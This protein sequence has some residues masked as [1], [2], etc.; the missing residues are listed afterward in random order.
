MAPGHDSRLCGVSL[1]D[2][3]HKAVKVKPRAA[4]AARGSL[5]EVS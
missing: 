3:W 4:A 5:T 1:L 2:T